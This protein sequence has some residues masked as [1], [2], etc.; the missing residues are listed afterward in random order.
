MG[1]EFYA[2]KEVALKL[3]YEPITIYRRIWFGDL[4]AYK[5]GKEYRISHHELT[6]FLR[7]CEY[8]SP[9]S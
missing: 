6:R 3:G 8:F 5:I 4:K 7:S 2:I 1:Q 9:Y